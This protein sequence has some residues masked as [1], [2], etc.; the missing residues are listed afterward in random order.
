M[1]F[2]WTK[3]YGLLEPDLMI[4]V[5]HD[6]E[7]DLH[8][9][10][11]RPSSKQK[12]PSKAPASRGLRRDCSQRGRRGGAPSGGLRLGSPHFLWVRKAGEGP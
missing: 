3:A 9:A 11:L 7:K 5:L 1:K 6:V 8:C 2:G 12:P 4:K 10:S